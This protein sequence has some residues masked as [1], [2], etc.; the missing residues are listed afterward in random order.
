MSNT[1]DPVPHICVVGHPNKGKSSI[2]ATLSENDSVR[3]GVESGTTRQADRFEFV[4]N[5]RVAMV[6]VDTPG[7]QRARQVMD[8]LASEPVT[9]ADRPARVRAFLQDPDC[10]ARF[11]D[12]VTLLQPIMDGAG[13]LFVVDAAQS[14]TAAD[15]AEMEILRWTGQPRMAVINPME[16]ASARDE[17]QRALSQFFQWVRV[18]NP[19]TATLPARQS[20]LRAMG[21]LSADWYRPISQLSQHLELRDQERLTSV[22]QEIAAYWCAQLT[23]RQPMSPLDGQDEQRVQQRLI[24]VLDQREADFFRELQ[25]RWGHGHA[26][27]ERTADWRV[28]NDHLMHTETWYLWGLKQ[29]E[30]MIVSGSA[31]AAAGLALDAGLGGSTFFLGTLSGGMLGS[32]SGWWASRQLPGKRWGWLPLSREQ[33]FAGPV[34]HPNFPLVVMARA[35]TFTQ[36]LWLRPHARRDAIAL[37]TDA[38]QWARAD[39]KQL[40]QWAQTLQKPLLGGLSSGRNRWTPATQQALIEWVQKALAQRLREAYREQQ[41]QVWLSDE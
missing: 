29:R 33:A 25:T 16:T 21:E 36:Q 40:L 2:V 15:E 9:P 30:L 17:W 32:A 11:P 22:S 41:N 19:L 1:P 31:G 10:V 18:F 26:V 24:H 13:I 27:F 7:F 39:Q 37:R 8:W 35:L 4:V 20:L 38:S 6:L 3:I 5:H 12:E 28:E 23:E 14:V 34:R